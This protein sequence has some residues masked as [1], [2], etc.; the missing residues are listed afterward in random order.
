MRRRRHVGADQRHRPRDRLAPAR[1][2]VVGYHLDRRHPRPVRRR[3]EQQSEA[4]ADP[5]ATV[6]SSPAVPA[7]AM[8]RPAAPVG[9][10][11]SRWRTRIRR[12]FAHDAA[13]RLQQVATGS[14]STAAGGGAG[15]AVD[16]IGMCRSRSA[17]R[18][19]PPVPVAR[20]ELIAQGGA[21]GGSGGLVVLDSVSINV[22]GS[23]IAQGGGGGAGGGDG[24]LPAN[25]ATDPTTVGVAAPGGTEGSGGGQRR[26]RRRRRRPGRTV[27]RAS[28]SGPAVA[29]AAPA[30]STRPRARWARSASASAAVVI[31]CRDTSSSR[32]GWRSS[33]TW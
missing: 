26:Q 17:A 27:P 1:A 6:A 14:Q 5:P 32:T 9:T 24:R 10:A 30:S 20:A 15:G 21:G 7:A 13:R 4:P 3:R 18:S 8:P 22:S 2:A 33:G 28:R 12:C 11:R 19:T 31:S 29:V 25:P 23:V 16:L